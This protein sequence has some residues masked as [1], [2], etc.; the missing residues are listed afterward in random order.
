V[1]E[2][3]ALD[4]IRLLQTHGADVVYHDPYIPVIRE[5]GHEIHG[6]ELTDAEIESA[7]VV[8]IVTDHKVIDYQRLMDKAGLVVD[9]RNATRH[10]VRT[11]ARVVTLTS[12]GRE[13]VSQQAF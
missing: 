12:A 10:G 1:R 7:D 8:V 4:I 9:T 2:S 13:A 3:P 6:V 5:D 11:K